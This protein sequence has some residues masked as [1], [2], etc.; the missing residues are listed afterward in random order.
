MRALNPLEKEI[1][2]RG[3][4]ALIWLTENRPELEK[5]GDLIQSIFSSDLVCIF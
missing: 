1:P 2:K 5:A 4:H 3:Q